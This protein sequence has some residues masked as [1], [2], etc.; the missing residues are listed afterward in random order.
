MKVS[1]AVQSFYTYACSPIYTPTVSLMT[2]R[3]NNFTLFQPFFMGSN[4][5][6]IAVF[7]RVDVCESGLSHISSFHILER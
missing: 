7:L 1:E 6:I 5:V 3:I 2:V 4:L